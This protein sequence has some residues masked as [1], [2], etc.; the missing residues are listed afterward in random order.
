MSVGDKKIAYE[1]PAAALNVTERRWNE[2]VIKNKR[3]FEEGNAKKAEAW[4]QKNLK[5]WEEQKKQIEA[6]RLINSGKKGE[7]REFFERI[8]HK[9]SDVYY[10]NEDKKK[11]FQAGLKGNAG[12]MAQNLRV[13]HNAQY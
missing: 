12:V 1:D 10:I 2:M 13:K 9:S 7:D 4:K 11:A 3:D 8:G 5:I 6:K